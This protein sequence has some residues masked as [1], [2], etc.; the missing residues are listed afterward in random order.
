MSLVNMHWKKEHLQLKND[1]FWK[2][3]V[4]EFELN[5]LAPQK[6]VAT[7]MSLIWDQFQ[8]F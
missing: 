1:D 8:T 3:F 4:S 2:I 7:Q 5:V 6:Q